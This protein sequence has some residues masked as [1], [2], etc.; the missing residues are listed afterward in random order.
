MCTHTYKY[1]DGQ[2]HT[3]DKLQNKSEEKLQEL[4]SLLAHVIQEQNSFN[5]ACHQ[6][7]SSTWFISL[8]LNGITLKF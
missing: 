3:K 8:A 6:A 1:G 2:W 5:Q 7:P 4:S